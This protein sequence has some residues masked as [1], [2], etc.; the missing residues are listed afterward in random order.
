MILPGRKF[1]GKIHQWNPMSQ[2]SRKVALAKKRWSVLAQRRFC[3]MRRSE[4]LRIRR[5]LLGT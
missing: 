3:G 2:Q 4:I 1:P 5:K